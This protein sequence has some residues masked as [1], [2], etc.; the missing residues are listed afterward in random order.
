MVHSITNEGSIN[1]VEAIREDLCLIFD[2]AS[3]YG[4]EYGFE[5]SMFI[6]IIGRQLNVLYD[7]AELVENESLQSKII[8]VIGEVE[9]LLKTISNKI[10]NEVFVEISDAIYTAKKYLL[11]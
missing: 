4:S 1:E 2:K 8:D 11:K 5:V 7:L 10:G 9:L 6:S 3:K